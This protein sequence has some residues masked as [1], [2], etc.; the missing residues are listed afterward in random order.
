VRVWNDEKFGVFV[1]PGQ[2]RP[3]GPGLRRWLEHRHLGQVQ[4]PSPGQGTA[5]DHLLSKDYQEKLG[6]AGLGPANS[7]Y[8]SALGTDAFAKATIESASNSKLTPA[9]PG[10]AA[11]ESKTLMEEFFG[12]LRDTNDIKALAAE[13]DAKIT[14]VLNVR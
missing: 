12:K 9:A 14:P 13:Y 1:A 3:A 2:R 5:D 7:D 10:W 6:A 8:F 11:V 4:E